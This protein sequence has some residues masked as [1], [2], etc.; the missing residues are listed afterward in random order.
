MS[1]VLVVPGNQGGTK[2]VFPSASDEH[3]SVYVHRVGLTIVL[4]RSMRENSLLAMWRGMTGSRK[5]IHN[6]RSLESM[7]KRE[8]AS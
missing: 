4:A 1:G 3:Q 2:D 7:I 6:W 8:I 5:I